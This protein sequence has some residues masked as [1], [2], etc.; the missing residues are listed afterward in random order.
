MVPDLFM[1][2]M[3][4]LGRLTI[5]V[6]MLTTLKNNDR[7]WHTRFVT[8]VSKIQVLVLSKRGGVGRIPEVLFI[9][10]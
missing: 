2:M 10:V 1:V 7:Q 6:G 3:A 5:I 9:F 4:P 8:L